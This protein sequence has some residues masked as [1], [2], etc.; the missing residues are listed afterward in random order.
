M[1]STSVVDLPGKQS[2]GYPVLKTELLESEA[3][4]SE[5]S[6]PGKDAV[7][8]SQLPSQHLAYINADTLLEAI[9]PGA[10]IETAY[11]LSP[12]VIDGERMTLQASNESDGTRPVREINNREQITRERTCRRNSVILD[13]KES[14]VGRTD[15]EQME[16]SDVVTSVHSS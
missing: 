4:L 2:I 7:G 10:N 5:T 13:W 6:V 15:P 16:M 3:E 12:E 9:S 14:D 11:Q 1:G 8:N